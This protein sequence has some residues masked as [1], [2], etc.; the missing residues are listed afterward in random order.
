MACSP[1]LVAALTDLIDSSVDAEIITLRANHQHILPGLEQALAPHIV[2]ARY[3]RGGCGIDGRV[4]LNGDHPIL[5]ELRTLHG[6]GIS[7]V[8]VLGQNFPS[9]VRSGLPAGKGYEALRFRV[10][11]NRD[12]EL[13]VLVLRPQVGVRVL[14]NPIRAA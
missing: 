7:R 2:T 3:G 8:K 11:R 1:L 13:G 6:D 12:N 14:E 4:Q 10:P 9:A 5:W